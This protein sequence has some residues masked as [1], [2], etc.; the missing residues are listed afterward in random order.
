MAHGLWLLI[1]D[2][3]RPAVE[4]MNLRLY[5]RLYRPHSVWFVPSDWMLFRHLV[6]HT[7]G[8]GLPCTIINC[9]LTMSISINIPLLCSA[10]GFWYKEGSIS[11]SLILSLYWH[12]RYVP[13]GTS[14][15]LALSQGHVLVHMLNSISSCQG[16]QI[17]QEPALFPKTKWE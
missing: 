5:F 8:A 3:G 11:R 12:S 16:T 6:A 10:C 15:F 7:Y 1:C 13:L 17:L 2:L 4:R 14:W 9:Q